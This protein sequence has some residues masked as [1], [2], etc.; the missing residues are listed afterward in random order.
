MSLPEMKIRN[1][2]PFLYAYDIEGQ[3]LA[4]STSQAMNE[5]MQYPLYSHYFGAIQKCREANCGWYIFPTGMVL[6]D[7]DCDEDLMRS[8]IFSDTLKRRPLHVIRTPTARPEVFWGR[9]MQIVA[10]VLLD[11]ERVLYRSP[12]FNLEAYKKRLTQS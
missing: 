6:Y 10:A 12:G 5:L 9:Q 4:V 7:R 8:F 11:D 1:N 2:H 3:A